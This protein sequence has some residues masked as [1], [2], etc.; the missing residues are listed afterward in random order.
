[1]FEYIEKSK[2]IPSLTYEEIMSKIYELD[3]KEKF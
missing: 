2:L 3:K 1:L